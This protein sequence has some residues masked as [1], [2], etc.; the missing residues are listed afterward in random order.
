MGNSYDVYDVL[1]D[2]LCLGGVIYINDLVCFNDVF[3]IVF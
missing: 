1:G 2:V 3:G